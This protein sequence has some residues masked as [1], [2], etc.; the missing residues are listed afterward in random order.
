MAPHSWSK[1]FIIIFW[2]SIFAAA[3][4]IG[5]IGSL[6]IYYDYQLINEYPIISLFNGGHIGLDEFLKRYVDYDRQFSIIGIGAGR[7]HPGYLFDLLFISKTFNSIDALWIYRAALFLI[8][9]TTIF[10]TTLIL[11]KNKILTVISSLLIFAHPGFWYVWTT[12]ASTTEAQAMTFLSAALFFYMRNHKQ[13]SI[14]N[15]ILCLLSVVV[16]FGFKEPVFIAVGVFSGTH[17]VLNF[18]SNGPV[19][20]KMDLLLLAVVFGFFCFYFAASIWPMIRDGISEGGLY[21]DMKSRG[22]KIAEGASVFWFHVQVYE[23]SD[24]FLIYVLLPLGVLHFCQMIFG[25][26]SPHDKLVAAFFAAGTVW[27]AQ[28]IVLEISDTYFKYYGVPAYCFAVPAIAAKINS[29]FFRVSGTPHRWISAGQKVMAIGLIFLSLI[30]QVGMK[31]NAIDWMLDNRMDFRYWEKTID[32]SA[33]IVHS[34]HPK[35]TYFYFYKSP[36]DSTI[37]LYESFTAFMVSRGLLPKDFDLTYASNH[38][39]AWAGHVPGLEMGGPSAPWGWRLNYRARPMQPGDYLIVN[40][41]WPFLSN[42]EID[43][44]LQDFELIFQTNGLYNCQTFS[45]RA[46]AHNLKSLLK[47]LYIK[48]V[49]SMVTNQNLIEEA[50]QANARLKYGSCSSF[51]NRRNF[52]IFRKI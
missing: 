39:I 15:V 1:T 45:I 30:I 23:R 52:Y 5:T 7:F 24:P 17:L 40:S 20:R 8:F 38:N 34:N 26:R 9:M 41:W 6:G 4:Y 46:V 22:T 36:R 49:P 51:T 42:A 21:F 14:W 3:F 44:V 48:I 33:E 32:K 12:L 29:I 16:A 50:K 2:V 11:V 25:S 27:L 47:E 37:E 10:G 35:K 13:E 19:S 28:Y 31:P 18:K 43:D